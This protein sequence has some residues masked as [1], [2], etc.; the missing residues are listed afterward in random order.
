MTYLW[1]NLT[2]GQKNY[3]EN[4]SHGKNHFLLLI[5]I[6]TKQFIEQHIS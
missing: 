4:L 6:I 3:A 5:V 2:A 1:D